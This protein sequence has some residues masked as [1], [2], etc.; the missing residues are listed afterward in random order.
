MA[1]RL[2]PDRLAGRLAK[3]GPDPVYYVAGSEGIL[4]DDVIRTV[5]DG[6]LDPG[7]R[8]FN[9][10]LLSAST[11][12]VDQL[13]AAC[14]TL[15]MMAD[16]RVVVIRDIEA[17]KRKS[18]AK[19]AATEYL[20]RPAADTVLVMIQGDTKDPDTDLCKHA[21]LVDC[22]APVG[23]ALDAW[24]DGQLAA[25]NVTL[26]PDA[27][28]HLQRAT[29]GDLGLLAAEVAKLGGLGGGDPLDRDTVGDLVGIRHGETVDDWRDAVLRD[30]LPAATAILPQILEQTG[31]SGVRLLFT[32]G[33]SLI[34]LQWARHAAKQRGLRGNAL[35]SA[36]RQLC[37][38]TR[39]MVGSYGPFAEIVSEVV[40]QWP[41]RRIALAVRLTLAADVS[42][43]STTIS[44]EEGIVTDLMLTLAASR[45]RKAA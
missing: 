23:E 12:A 31:I 20:A 2:T 42:L 44:T 21:T 10:D 15:P 25:A 22:S 43:K 9:L 26:M 5:I 27:R 41:A 33:A 6:V 4:K 17:W 39:P 14:S 8:D 3:Q 40:G 34:A 16:R 28:E 11:L 38:D 1:A 29:R 30:D 35:T 13:A 32:L 24:L 18:K 7:L 37:F 19:T 36:V 45:P